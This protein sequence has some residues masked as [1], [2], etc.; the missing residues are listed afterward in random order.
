MEARFRSLLQQIKKHTMMTAIIIVAGVLVTAL[1]VVVILGYW[2]NWPWV[3]VS[4]GNSKITTTTTATEQPP[5]K[6]LWDW[7]NLLG[8]LAIPVV[9]GIGAAWFT[10]KQG[11]ESDRENTDNQREKALQDYIDKIS[12]LLLHEHLGNQF[13]SPEP[14]T[15]Q[16]QV[17]AQAR[18]ATVLRTLDPNR[19]GSLIQFLSQAGILNTCIQNALVEIDLHKAKLQLLNLSN[20]NL[21]SANLVEAELYMTDLSKANL[22]QANLTQA[23]MSRANLERANLNQATLYQAT[24]YK[25]NLN[26]ANLEKANLS[27]A[28]L[29]GAN[30]SEANLKGAIGITNEE[31]EKQA[32]SLEGATMPDGSKHP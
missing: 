32:K 27:N 1:I 28:Y 8:V 30:L 3:G 25:T 19:R 9:V 24:L 16:V 17:I 2:F 4:G 21:G 7:L 14:P 22:Y 10:T 31:L 6:T 29:R 18:T 5:A 13:P 12:E 20:I 26:S 23:Y 11:K 15:P